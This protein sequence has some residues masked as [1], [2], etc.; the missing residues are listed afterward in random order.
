[1]TKQQSDYL[2]RLFNYYFGRAKW[3]TAEGGTDFDYL[4]EGETLYLYFQWTEQAEDNAN[5]FDFPATPYRDMED[6]WYAH[7]GFLR[8]WK[9]AE[10]YLKDAIM[11]Q[12]VK[13]IIIIGYSH[14]AA[15]ATL[16]HE[17][18]WYNRPDLRDT[19]EGYGFGCPR[20]FWG[21]LTPKMQ[22]RWANF[23][24]ILN[25]NDIVT[26]V[27]PRLFGFKHVGQP[28]NIDSKT[29]GWKFFWDAHMWEAYEQ[30]L[31]NAIDEQEV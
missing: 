11:D 21:K 12:A 18:V 14:G 31:K 30:G 1:M 17:Y 13:K 5:N 25:K 23:H 8:G 27:P 9:N 22:E 7:R 16:A 15:L 20:V 3:Q 26:H 29:T 19:L 2:L 6:K 4:R 10:P 24:P 28:I